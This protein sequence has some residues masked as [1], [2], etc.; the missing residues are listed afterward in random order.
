MCVHS[1]PYPAEQQSRAGAVSSG[2]AGGPPRTAGTDV[3]WGSCRSSSVWARGMKS[4]RAR[5]RGQTQSPGLWGRR[6]QSPCRGTA[7]PGGG[8]PESERPVEAGR[9]ELL[10]CRRGAHILLRRREP[11]TSRHQG[12]DIH[13]YEVCRNMLISCVP[14]CTLPFC[15]L[16]K[17]NKQ[18]Y[19]IRTIVQVQNG[20][21]YEMRNITTIYSST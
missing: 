18:H 9:K 13:I 10:F 12:S 1:C 21:L 8:P 16:K 14:M 15:T 5:C 4:K 6:I 7:P 2:P 17:Y 11:D 20:R 3:W 19:L